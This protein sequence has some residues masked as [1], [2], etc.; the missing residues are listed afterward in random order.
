METG[1]LQAV[2]DKSDA[3]C[4]HIG[5]GLNKVEKEGINMAIVKEFNPQW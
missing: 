5:L 1:G 4:T 2:V 3:I